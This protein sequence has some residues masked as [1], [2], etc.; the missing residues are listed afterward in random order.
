MKKEGGNNK[1]VIIIVIVV[2]ILL[3]LAVLVYFLFFNKSSGLNFGFASIDYSPS[4]KVEGVIGQI[5][6]SNVW[7]DLKLNPFRNETP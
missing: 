5:A 4:G 1:I 3:V 6:D 2:L 7:N